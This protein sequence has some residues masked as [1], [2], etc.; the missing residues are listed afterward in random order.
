[1]RDRER[2]RVLHASSIAWFRREPAARATLLAILP[3][4]SVT[5]PLSRSLR[6]H[7]R[8]PSL[9][10]V[11]RFFNALQERPGDTFEVVRLVKDRTRVYRMTG[12]DILDDLRAQRQS[13]DRRLFNPYCNQKRVRVNYAGAG[14]Y[15]SS[16]T[17]QLHFLR[18]L[19]E[20]GYVG[21][22]YRW[23][24]IEGCMSKK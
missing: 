24:E 11:E 17:G 21:L 12:S 6:L 18:W 23:G 8:V 15:V 7:A 16:D 13:F 20:S 5:P 4:T 19:I 10:M 14:V 22:I 3:Q 2:E 9:R 1:M